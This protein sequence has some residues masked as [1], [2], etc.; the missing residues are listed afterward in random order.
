[1]PLTSEQKENLLQS[2]LEQ[3]G[4]PAN[5]GDRVDAYC[6]GLRSAIEILASCSTLDAELERE[7]DKCQTELR[8]L[9]K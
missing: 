1:M 5:I 3:T 6:C 7:A 4:V 2:M 8:L 9:E